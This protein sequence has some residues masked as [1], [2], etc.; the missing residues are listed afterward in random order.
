MRFLVNSR[1]VESSTWAGSPAL[2]FLRGEL[3]LLGTKEGCREGDCGACAVLVGDFAAGLPRYRAHPSCLMSLGELE[4]RHLVTI[5]GLAEGA[6]HGG[7]EAG[8][9]PVMRALLEEN[10]SQ[11]GFCSP[12]FVISLTAWL[13]EGD[14]LSED[15]ALRA[16]E[17][18]LCR[19]T[20]YASIRRAAR[21]LLAEF[22]SLPSDPTARIEG[23]VARG[24]VPASLLDFARGSIA[25]LGS[26]GPEAPNRPMADSGETRL[27]IG[28]GSDLYV[29]D[30][31]PEAGPAPFYPRLEARL[32][33]IEDCGEEIAVGGGV[34]IRDFFG[35]PLVLDAFPGIGAFEAA[36]ASILVR[37]RATLA[38]NLVNA[39]PVADMT[40]MLLG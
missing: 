6:D 5:E 26:T 40:A 10:G 13:L 18:N 34:S 37:N 22:P 23:L 38:G 3:G 19:C 8:L 11:C 14:R 16:V 32:L 2:D 7:L 27:V 17:G 25:G 9:T 33:S 39:S 36:F 28:G 1:V 20:G 12:G 4:G 15:G 31:H 24:V 35:S 30:P 29:R 21:L